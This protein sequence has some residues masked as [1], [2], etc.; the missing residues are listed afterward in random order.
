MHRELPGTQGAPVARLSYRLVA[1][2]AAVFLLAGCSQGS[3]TSTSAPLT[4]STT[5]T[6]PPAPS[7]APSGLT[8]VAIGDSIPF[9]SPDDCPGCTGFIDRYADA[10]AEA[11]GRPVEVENL[12]SHSG[13]TLPRLLDGLEFQQEALAAADIIVV[14][15]AHNSAELASDT[16]CGAPLTADDMPDWS[17][18]DQKCAVSAAAGY[19]PQFEELFSRLS[20]M[21]EGKPT[22]LR[23]VNRYNDWIGW[24]EGNLDPAQEA[25]TTLI[26]DEWNNVLCSAAEANGFTCVDIYHAF[27]GP[28]GAE[29]AGDLLAADYTHPSEEGNEL[30][31][32]LMT[33]EG[34]APLA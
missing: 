14:G 2:A 10:A 5:T 9:N 30:I 22:V 12:S 34:F 27:N 11:L 33:A 7:A 24:S 21:R 25:K 23:T 4:A 26:L 17:K 28:D 29:A 6:Q 8:L 18:M 20:V 13:L 31:T 19:R 1:C 16:P 3:T 15:I 32:R